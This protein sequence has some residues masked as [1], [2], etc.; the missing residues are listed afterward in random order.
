[1]TSSEAVVVL[2]TFPMD[3]DVRRFASTLVA[4][5][6]AACVSILPDVESVYRWQ[7]RVEQARERQLIV[8]TQRAR[9]DR[10]RRRVGD[11][12]PYDTPE[13]VV[14][15]VVDGDPRYLTWIAEATGGASTRPDPA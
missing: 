10:L 11:L 7:G 3:A 9:V 5:G 15:P 1:M 2:I 4:E 6:C 12:H 14:L 13:F 8:K